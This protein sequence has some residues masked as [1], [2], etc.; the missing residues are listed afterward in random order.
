[1]TAGN[2]I[3]AIVEQSGDNTRADDDV[4]ETTYDDDVYDEASDDWS[5]VTATRNWRW[6][7]PLLAITAVIG[8]T[9]VFAWVHRAEMMTGGTTALWI[10]WIAAWAVP[11]LLIVSIW[12]LIMRSSTRES[13]RFGMIANT[14][15]TEAERLEDRLTV[16]NRELSLAR[17]FLGT[18]ARELDSLGRVATDRLSTHADTLQHLIG[19]NG[20]QID[21]IGAVS[22]TALDN[23]NRLRD[24]L[25]VIAN[26][27]KDV[28]NQIGTAGMT[29]HTHI[30][31][32]VGGFERLN[33]FGKASED[34]VDSIQSKIDVTLSSFETRIAELEQLAADR[35]A[36]LKETSDDMKADL[37][38]REVGALASIRRRSDALGEEMEKAREQLERGE[39][40]AS[41]ALRDRMNVLRENA[42]DI[43]TVLRDGEAT[44][45]STWNGQID[46]MKA[47]LVEAIE[48]VQ[49]I[50][51]QA[52][53]AANEKL[54]ALRA[55][56]EVMEANMRDRDAR[57]AA[58][59]ADRRAALADNETEG[60]AALERQLDS[61]DT[62]LADRRET[63]LRHAEHLAE[64]TG[65]VAERIGTLD[66][67]LIK[68]AESSDRTQAL[69]AGNADDI[70]AKFVENG[71]SLSDM[72]TSIGEMTDACV[73]LLEL[74]Q[75]SAQHTQTEMPNALATAEKRLMQV[76]EEA[77]E[78]NEVVE[79][80][81]SNAEALSGHIRQTHEDERG[82]ITELDGLQMR[83][84]AAHANNNE[85]LASFRTD[86]SGISDEN[87]VV[88]EKTRA[89]LRETIAMLENAATTTPAAITQN[90]RGKVS[91]LADDLAEQTGR[92]LEQ[93]LIEN[94]AAALDDFRSTATQ[95]NEHAIVSANTL[96]EQL[97]EVA[98]LTERLEDRI[99]QARNRA[100][101]NVNSDFSRRLAL[102][103]ES[104]N[105]NS[106]DIAKAMSVDV[107]DTAW[108]SYL[109]GDRGIFTRR[110]V[111]LL[112]NSDARTI[113][114]IYDEDGVFREN[115]SRYIHDFEAM[116][117]NI[118]STRDGHAL[119]VTILSSDIGKLYVALAQA[120]ERFRD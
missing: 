107:A 53:D 84:S 93:T 63:Q 81:A 24:D 103:T 6:L 54:E 77:V 13:E 92:V 109:K 80:A 7:P 39:N 67:T 49:R 94:T 70:E 74:V 99:E 44:A 115:V 116:L 48:E 75:A 17:E 89:D 105:S 60:L 87:E 18:Q 8:W 73:R 76:R 5:E 61:F 52:L 97:N 88:L 27:A 4:V 50:D 100:L 11:V 111:R 16:I 78:L 3:R 95:A 1:M 19:E 85:A 51:D 82:L 42:A 102:L 12:L 112:D 108:A 32:L 91:G 10:D 68:I 90:L 33:D 110:A 9:A 21:A 40:V 31:E 14:L 86:L 106:I 38:A 83:V 98:T 20:A 23:M 30:A 101:E 22:N 59:I 113:A 117:R 56:A 2:N 72:K 29:A 119:S 36:A 69:I 79:Q 55:E 114:E 28:S 64:R 41:D 62:D 15:S 58:T 71:R 47:R 45:L 120:I 46:R 65:A 118:L 25:P 34:Q 96:R 43:D 66:A 104:L 35:F 57:L 37:D 26:S